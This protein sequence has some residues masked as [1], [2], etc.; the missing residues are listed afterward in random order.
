[1]AG[2]AVLAGL[3]VPLAVATPAAAQNGTFAYVANLNDDTVSVIDAAT[4]T[5]VDTITVGD[6]P[7]N[8]AVSPDGSRVYVTNFADDTVSVID[9]ATN[10]VIDT[11]PVGDGPVGVAIG[12]VT[13]RIPTKLKLRLE[14]KK[15]KGKGKDVVDALGDGGRKGLVLKAKLTAEG[16]PLEGQPIE[17]TTDSVELCTGTTDSKGKATCK[18]PCKQDS[19]TCYTAT[20]A[21][22]DTY[23]PST[24]T[25]CRFNDTSD[26]LSEPADPEGLSAIPNQALTSAART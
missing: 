9:T 5:V 6:T 13:E 18:V 25:F 8:V 4:N 20:F 14:K 15:G 16:E 3:A 11:I 22:D 21:G 23:E 2:L 10:T 7:L 17:F 26:Q 1:M 24:A 12:T 19:E